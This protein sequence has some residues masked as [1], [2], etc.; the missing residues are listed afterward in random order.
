M[1]NKKKNREDAK[2]EEK[3]ENEDKGLED[4]KKRFKQK[5]PIIKNNK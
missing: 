2:E 3:D 4:I 5:K 1:L